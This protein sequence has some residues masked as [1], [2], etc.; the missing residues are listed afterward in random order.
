MMVTF[1]STSVNLNIPGDGGTLT[2]VLISIFVQSPHTYVWVDSTHLD[3]YPSVCVF[4]DPAIEPVN[5]WSG[6]L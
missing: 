5:P 4:R 6:I 3:L 2:Y 1:C